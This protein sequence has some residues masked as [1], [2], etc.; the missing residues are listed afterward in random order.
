MCKLG[1]V[2]NMENEFHDVE[3]EGRGDAPL[4]RECADDVESETEDMMRKLKSF[5]RSAWWSDSDDNHVLSDDDE[6]HKSASAE[7]IAIS[8]GEGSNVKKKNE[9][10]ESQDDKFRCAPG[11][12]S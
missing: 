11:K 5:K 6:S 3:E 4:H 8:V 12:A 2:I 1:C 7:E 9:E 10:G